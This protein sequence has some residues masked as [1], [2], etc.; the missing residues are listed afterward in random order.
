[1]RKLKHKEA[2]LLA[3]VYTDI[4]ISFNSP[5]INWNNKEVE[6]IKTRLLGPITH[7]QSSQSPSFQSHWTVPGTIVK[8]FE[9]RKKKWLVSYEV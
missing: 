5:E 6:V 1:M 7:N 8:I 2:K 3:H 9:M 4:N